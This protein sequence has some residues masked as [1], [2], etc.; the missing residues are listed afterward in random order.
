MRQPL[1]DRLKLELD[2]MRGLRLLILCALMFMLV[3]F[4]ANM[5]LRSA[6]RLGLLHTNTTIFAL[7]PDDLEGTD[8]NKSAMC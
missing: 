2:L 8:A 5:E 1:I 4:A 7:N 3:I 6:Q